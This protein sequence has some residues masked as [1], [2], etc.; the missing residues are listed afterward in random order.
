MKNNY[1]LKRM[2]LRKKKKFFY[3]KTRRKKNK[4][5]ISQWVNYQAV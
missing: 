4:K 1:K 3:K 2:T 5:I